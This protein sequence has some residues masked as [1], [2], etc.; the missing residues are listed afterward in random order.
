MES[1]RVELTWALSKISVRLSIVCMSILHIKTSDPLIVP[2][3]ASTTTQSMTC[4]KIS[5]S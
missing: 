5:V 2:Y 1:R 3:M 4:T